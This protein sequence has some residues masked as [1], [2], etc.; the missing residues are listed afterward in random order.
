MTTSLARMRNTSLQTIGRERLAARG[1]P[2]ARPLEDWL[3]D[4]VDVLG[5]IPVAQ[6]AAI[7]NYTSTY[8]CTAAIHAAHAANPGKPLYFAPGLYNHT[9]LHF[10]TGGT[11]LI[12]QPRNITVLNNT[13]ATSTCVLFSADNYDNTSG[14]YLNN[15]GIQGITI[16]RS[17]DTAT[18]IGLHTRRCGSFTIGPDTLITENHGNFLIEGCINGWYGPQARI[19]GGG[20]YTYKAG[21]FNV[22]I[23]SLTLSD[24][25]I[26]RGFTHTFIEPFLTGLPMEFNFLIQSNDFLRVLGGYFGGATNAHCCI[27]PSHSNS[28]IYNVEFD[29]TYFDGAE[30]PSGDTGLLIEADPVG[31]TGSEISLVRFKNMILAQLKQVCKIS[32]KTDVDFIDFE[33]CD[34]HNIQDS[35]FYVDSTGC[36]FRFDGLV[37]NFGTQTA[38]SAAFDIVNAKSAKIHARLIT[39]G[40]T[41]V[42]VR[43]AGTLSSEDVDIEWETVTTPY[44]STAT[45]P[46]TAKRVNVRGASGGTIDTGRWTQDASGHLV[47]KVTNAYDIGSLAVR[48]R[49]LY[50][51]G[52]AVLDGQIAALH[53]ELQAAGSIYWTGRSVIRSP[54]DG[55]VSIVNQ[56]GTLGGALQLLERT[57]PAAPAA[58]IGLLYMRDNGSGKTQLVARFPTGAI[59]VIATEP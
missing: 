21:S 26:D 10:K 6:H 16:T 13:S 59:Q 44:V 37:F 39:G 18:G 25:S 22:K 35:A 56:A 8:D 27:K 31:V 36:R 47:P 51:A 55:I 32:G 54:A 15:C 9:A 53:T 30:Y 49:N 12:G 4:S 57:D 3:N 41:S 19:G 45:V 58:N 42:G 43:T 7:R 34:V 29:G 2:I 28:D 38:G 33:N 52:G 48:A 40:A 5:F 17:V 24:L 23:D 14:L 11:W 1:A 50:L 20:V 46:A